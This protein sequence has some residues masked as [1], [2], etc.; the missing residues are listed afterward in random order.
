MHQQRLPSIINAMHD[1]YRH[2]NTL[3]QSAVRYLIVCVFLRK[4]GSFSILPQNPE[5]IFAGNDA[6]NVNNDAALPAQGEAMRRGQKKAGN[7]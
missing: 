4:G 1:G 6:R 3:L 2:G 7:R 5:L